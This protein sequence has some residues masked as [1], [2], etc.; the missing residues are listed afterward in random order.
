MLEPGDTFLAPMHE[1]DISHLYVVLIEPD[2]NGNA[3]CANFTDSDN[4]PDGT[5][6]CQPGE[7]PFLVKESAIHNAEAAYLNVVAVEQA[8]KQGTRVTL[9]E[10]CDAKLLKKIRDGV[11]DS[12]Y[13]HKNIKGPCKKLRTLGKF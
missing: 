9:H 13:T 5:T 3:I 10:R 6:V 4:I 8:A 7:H 12:P 11:L 2:E 1:H